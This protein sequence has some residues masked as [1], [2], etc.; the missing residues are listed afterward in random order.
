MTP[1][2]P[3][4]ISG[5]SPLTKAAESLG[6]RS[7]ADN[8]VSSILIPGFAASKAALIESQATSWGGWIWDDQIRIAFVAWAKARR[9]WALA[10]APATSAPAPPIALR[11]ERRLRVDDAGWLRRSRMAGLLRDNGRGF[12]RHGRRT[13]KGRPPPGEAV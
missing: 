4:T 7:A 5:C 2:P 12:G 10:A 13:A 9:Q 6:S 1:A 3:V 11:A 8:F